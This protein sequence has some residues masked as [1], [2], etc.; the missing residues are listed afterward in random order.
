MGRKERERK[1]ENILLHKKRETALEYGL[2][3]EENKEE[4]GGGGGLSVIGPSK[5]PRG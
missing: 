2:I 4:W 5:H 3:E 1:E